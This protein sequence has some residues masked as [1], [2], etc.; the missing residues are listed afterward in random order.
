[1]NLTRRDLLKSAAV[2][3]VGV[4][5]LNMTVAGCAPQTNSGELAQSGVESKPIAFRAGTYE[6]SA[7][8]KHGPV[9]T[10]VTF[11]ESSI[12]AI[13]V[14][15]SLETDN[16]TDVAREALP[17]LILAT[18][19]LGVDTVSGATLTS[20]AIIEAVADC[21]RQAGADD[22][23][24]KSRPVDASAISQAM[25]PGT[26]I[27]ESYGMWGANSF[28]VDWYG[29]AAQVLPTKVSVEVTESS[30]VSVTVDSCSDTAGFKEAP[31]ER[32]PQSI[33][34][35]QSV[36][37]DV[38]SGATMTSGAI[39]TATMHALQQA[40]ADIAGFAIVPVKEDAEPKS[41]DCD[42][43]IIGAGTAGTTAALRATELGLNVVI[44]DV[45]HRV[46][47]AGGTNT[48]PLGVDSQMHRDAGFTDT[49][50]MVFARMMEEGKWRTNAPLVRN[51]LNNSGRT[52]DWLQE[53]WTAIGDP[54]FDPPMPGDPYNYTC[55]YYSGTQKYTDL[56]DHYIL[57]SSGTLLPGVRMQKLLMEGD[58]VIG[59]SGTNIDTGAEV[60]VNAKAVV[61][62]TG[63]FGANPAKLKERFGTDH[64]YL[65]GMH[66]NV[67]DGHDMCLEVGCQLSEDVQPALAEFVA[68]PVVDFMSGSMQYIC[69][70]GFLALDPAGNRFMNEEKFLTAELEEGGSAL[71]RVGHGY[72]LFTQADY[73]SMVDHG[74][75]EFCS[76]DYIA[77]EDLRCDLS[78]GYPT[79][80]A[81]MDECLKKGQ[82]FKADTLEELC[83][84]V[85]F[86]EEGFASAVSEYNQACAA[87][88]DPLFGK[89]AEFLNPLDRGPFYAVHII[90]P[91]F[92][93][94]GGIRIDEHFRPLIGDER[95][96]T[97]S[98]L[99]VAGQD[100]GGA[101]TYPYTNFIG[102]SCSFALTS[103]MLAA[104]E[105]QKY[106]Q[107]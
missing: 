7:L 23:A 3:A 53:K 10:A 64:F 27:G 82:A 6:G 42:L 22:R 24:L 88:S 43:L 25:N 81:E 49:P 104:E 19:S 86:D 90:P 62:A 63:G 17:A 52:L 58:S 65:L 79:L 29:A 61:V 20:M 68:N 32:V 2:A 93:T 41:Y 34:D 44:A 69:Q 57:P 36:A 72:I 47:G 14:D 9:K 105:A 98:G 94:Y 16:L 101:F 76:Q 89:S 100:A 67:G 97:L 18:Q 46:S 96:P 102:S 66:N 84:V 8:G 95:R 4:G 21:A 50:D 30:I 48:G 99:F 107:S 33:V 13:E 83:A 106:L 60:T 75:L 12:T 70:C 91:I 37:V 87:G 59:A 31:L 74:V 103:G 71:R 38:V 80:P 45:S 11:D 26:Y 85:G 78:D 15:A 40:G 55:V 1:M 54:G 77:K 92:S 28:G 51:W 56:Y 39:R 73:D 5:A 35:G